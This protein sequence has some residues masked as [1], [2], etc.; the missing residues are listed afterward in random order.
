MEFSEPK[1]VNRCHEVKAVPRPQ[2]GAARA[3]EGGG[4]GKCK[5]LCLQGRKSK[6]LEGIRKNRS[7]SVFLKAIENRL[8]ENE[9]AQTFLAGFVALWSGK[10]ALSPT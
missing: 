7:A 1:L 3:A 4:S 9:E 6:L 8:S 2:C 5:V 10:S